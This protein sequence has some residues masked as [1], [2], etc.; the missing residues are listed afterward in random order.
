MW[1]TSLGTKIFKAK[2]TIGKFIKTKV[3]YSD[4]TKETSILL[5]SMCGCFGC[6]LH[7]VETSLSDSG[8]CPRSFC[9]SKSINR[10]S[11]HNRPSNTEFK[12]LKWVSCR[13]E[14][15][16]LVSTISFSQSLSDTSGFWSGDLSFSHIVG[17]SWGRIF[18]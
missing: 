11:T 2:V 9:V 3:Y 8:W 4:I 14:V 18:H 7:D 1:T 5:E 6:P 16:L 15:F 12:T 10:N 17:T 13:S